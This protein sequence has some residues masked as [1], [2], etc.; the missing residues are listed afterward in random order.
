MSAAYPNTSPRLKPVWHLC[1]WL[2]IY[3][4]FAYIDSGYDHRY[5]RAFVNQAILLPAKIAFAYCVLYYLIPRFLYR[6]RYY[7][8]LALLVLFIFLGATAYRLLQGYFILGRY[9]PKLPFTPFDGG[10]FLWASFDV[11]FPAVI[12]ASAKLFKSRYES[13]QR[14]QKLQN[15]NL[16]AELR[17][18]KAQVSPHFLFNTLNN[19]YG[20]SLASSPMASEAILKLS[21]V[22]RFVL[23]NAASRQISIEE[24]LAVLDDYIALERLRYGERL[25]LKFVK[26]IQVPGQKIAPLILLSLVENAFKHGASESLSNPFIHIDLKVE[27]DSLLFTITNSKEQDVMQGTEGIGLSN[28]RRQLELT[29]QDNYSL[30]IQNGDLF[31]RLSLGINLHTH[32]QVELHDH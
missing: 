28:I 24:E 22:L 31:Y 8:F 29:Y 26:E 9:S 7:E 25:D 18:L 32:E 5:R 3:L 14:E 12:A 20:L 21:E 27:E 17:F 1:F 15:E 19:I 16:R 13:A 10:R 2:A 4:F 23:H 30:D 11:S 6:K